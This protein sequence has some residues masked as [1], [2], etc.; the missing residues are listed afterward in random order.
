MKRM[1]TDYAIIMHRKCMDQ[2]IDLLGGLGLSPE[3]LSCNEFMSMEDYEL[4]IQRYMEFQTEPDAGF[5][6][7]QSFSMANHGSLGFGA[8]CAP[9]VR[10]GLLFLSRYLRTRTCYSNCQIES[11]PA[12]IDLVFDLDEAVDHMPAQHCETFCQIFQSFIESTG[13]QATETVWHF[14]YRAPP[15][16]N[17]YAEWIKGKYVFGAHKLRL[18]VPQHVG[19][20]PSAF[21]ND[22]AYKAAEAQCEAI[23]IEG[24]SRS[25][26][27]EKV[28]GLLRNRFEQRTMEMAP[29]TEIPSADEIADTL[30][31]SRRN[32]IRKLK[33]QGISFQAIKD[34]LRREYLQRLIK[35]QS[36]SVA[37]ISERLGYSDASN[38][39]RACIKLFGKTPR[40]LRTVSA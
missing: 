12:G 23:L 25:T 10:N 21:A 18:E 35:D 36:L 20:T 7:G 27:V 37:E 11:K 33:A 22:A 32:L 15:H 2:G 5:R 26:I 16:K 28:A 6:L 40:E 9:N 34:D 19:A 4:V 13:A 38:L 14:P 30:T 8:I 3:E 17:V 29:V 31:M 39:T 1:P 24:S